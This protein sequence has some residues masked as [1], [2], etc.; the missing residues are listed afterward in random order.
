MSPD[1]F[2]V[3]RLRIA[4]GRGFTVEDQS[5][6]RASLVVNQALAATYFGGVNPV[7][8]TW[9]LRG[10]QVGDIVGVVE[11][12]HQSSLDSSP[13]PQLFMTTYQ[14][15]EYLPVAPAGL[16]FAIRTN[17]PPGAVVP[18]IRRVVRA[19]DPLAVVD[20]VATMDQIVANSICAPRAYAM[21]LGVFAGAAL[22]LAGV[23]TYGLVAYIVAH[24]TSEIGVRMALGAQRAEVLVLVLRRV[25][26][27]TALGTGI[28]L[29]A[30]LLVTRYLES[31]LFGITPLDAVTF[32][33]APLLFAAVVAVA[34]CRP[35]LRATRVDPLVA[36]RYE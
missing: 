1:Y 17:L 2:R 29:L 22:L 10:R 8:R 18:R 32:G 16:Y 14:T 5:R 15:T 13:E 25:M 26:A 23:G 36:L 31:M 19:I 9:Y 35:A 33:F 24:R 34:C 30:G 20:N 12:V 28:G 11:N 7:G 6:P 4:S 21:V 3:M 27:M